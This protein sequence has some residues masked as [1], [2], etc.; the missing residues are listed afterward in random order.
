MSSKEVGV[1]DFGTTIF[2]EFLSSFATVTGS[3]SEF[4]AIFGFGPLKHSFPK[5]VADALTAD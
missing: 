4:G 1:V 5:L 2:V 3:E